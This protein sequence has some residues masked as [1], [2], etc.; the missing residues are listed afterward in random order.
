MYLHT[1][2]DTDVDVS[3]LKNNNTQ[4]LA[5]VVLSAADLYRATV[6]LT[7]NHPCFWSLVYL[8][9]VSCNHMN[10]CLEWREPLF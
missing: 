5:R 10:T 3:V 1:Y 7:C 9:M 4:S 2:V 6:I 8:L